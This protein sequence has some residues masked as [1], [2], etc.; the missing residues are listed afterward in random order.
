MKMQLQKAPYRPKICFQTKPPLRQHIPLAAAKHKGDNSPKL[1]QPSACER[2]RLKSMDRTRPLSRSLK[3]NPRTTGKLTCVA[4]ATLLAAAC[5]PTRINFD[6]PPGSVMFVNDKPYHL[7]AQIEFLRPAGVGQS[8]RYNISLVF[9]LPNVGEVRAKGFIDVY[10][11]AESDVDKLVANSY[12][13]DDDNLAKLT[14]GTTLVF[15]A[16]TSSRQPLYDLTL[17]KQ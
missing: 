11:Y 3:M 4:L 14:Q 1:P 6:A 13:L 10:G 15:K 5:S 7:P 9:T 8:N 2:H 17:T 12:K 16:H